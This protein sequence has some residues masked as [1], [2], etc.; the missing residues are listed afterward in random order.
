MLS[1]RF[2]ADLRKEPIP[3]QIDGFDELERKIGYTFKNKQLL[4]CALTHSSYANESNMHDSEHKISSYERLE[5]FGDSILSFVVSEYIYKNYPECPEGE[6][7]RL[8]AAVVC[9]E[10]LYE[11]ATCLS[12]DKFMILGN[13][14]K[15]SGGRGRKS[16]LADMVEAIIAAV[17]ID[18][19][20][21]DSKKFII[22]NL[23]SKIKSLM[24]SDSVVDYK[25]E[26]Q[27]LVQQAPGEKFE[28]E[29]IGESGPDHDKRFIMA[30]KLNTNIIGKGT[31][32]TKREAEQQAA[33]E[34]LTL[35]GIIKQ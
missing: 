17:F 35:F 15:H 18:S 7:T 1:A 10:S 24:G 33:K 27:H 3:M 12:I 11:V 25:T 9:E 23:E 20:L 14:E 29:L 8:R 13:G 19:G 4:F 34:A 5:F 30:A 28:Y 32:R 16:V 22:D 26:L 6:L 2:A 31:G 21:S